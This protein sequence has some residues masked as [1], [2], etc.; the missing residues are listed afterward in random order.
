MIITFIIILQLCSAYI[1]NWFPVVPISST[2][3]NNPKQIRILGKDLV[4]WKK[5]NEYIIQNNV[6]PHRCAP[7]SEGYIDKETNNLR[8]AYHGWEFNEKGVCKDIPQM[9][10]EDKSVEK[11]EWFSNC[12]TTY[13]THCY[14]DLLWVYTGNKKINHY[15]E[16]IYNL[17]DSP[18]FMRDLPYGLYILLENFFDPAHIPFAHHKLQG[19]KE[20]AKPIKIKL[21]SNLNDTNK[22][23]VLFNET[24]DNII[25]RIG[26]M[27]FTM[28]CH[29]TLESKM[30]NSKMNIVNGI[31]IFAVPIQKDKTRLF[32]QYNFNKENL[33]YKLYNSIPIWMRHLSLNRFLDSDTYILHKQEKY[34]SN[35]NT[36]HNNKEYYTPTSSDKSV[37]LYQKWIKKALPNIPFQ[38]DF[39]DNLLS[40]EQV[41]NR[42]EQ[43][44]KHCTHCS[45]VLNEVT[46]FQ[47]YFTSILFMIGTYSGNIVIL[48]I[49]LAN[50]DICRKIIEKL[51]FEDYIHNE[52]D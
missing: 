40:R 39:E 10:K 18:I 17:D 38:Q 28:P 36:Y 21:L 26:I 41:L 15:P 43:H 52:I 32:V 45:N 30:V 22:F 48:F 31:N 1:N 5:D 8:C 46:Y 27:N 51:K 20:R 50:F 14:G 19:N 24:D 9:K 49:A 23:S 34:L 6:C 25:E 7:L 35:I 44:T 16:D 47:I 2:D 3:F 33:N 42:Y 11:K 12:L 4:L 37:R 13:K 29:Y